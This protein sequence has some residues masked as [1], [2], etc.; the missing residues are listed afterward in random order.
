MKKRFDIVF[1]GCYSLFG[2][3]YSKNMKIKNQWSVSDISKE[4]K[5]R[6]NILEFQDLIGEFHDFTIV[7]TKNRIVFGGC[8][9]VGFL[10]SGYIEREEF[11]TLDESL[12]ELLADLETYYNY[13]PK[14]VSRIVCNE[15]M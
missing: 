10:E 15:R 4:I 5:M 11:E 12:S 6:S 1:G 13:G 8:Y 3:C 7:A 9:N 2:G 14:R